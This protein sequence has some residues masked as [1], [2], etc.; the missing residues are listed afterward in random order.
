MKG[1]KRFQ[2]FSLGFSRVFFDV[3]GFRA[4]RAL[5]GDG[6]VALRGASVPQRAQRL[7]P[8]RGH[9]GAASRLRGRDF[10]QKPMK[11]NE[12]RSISGLYLSRN[13]ANMYYI[14]I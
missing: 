2:A 3:E 8:L 1:F 10:R 9:A 12:F 4:E 6:A 5:A 14:A 11:F 7:L 13:S